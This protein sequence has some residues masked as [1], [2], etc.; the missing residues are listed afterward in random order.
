MTDAVA[1]LRFERDYYA[2]LGV[3]RDATS[4][5]IRSHFLSLSREFHPDRQS[6][7]HDNA[8]LVA[9]ANAQYAVLDRAYKVLLDPVKRRVYDIY[10]EK[11]SRR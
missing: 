8:A 6:R 4:D 9:A 11:V 3:P 2:L 10:G 7:R 5:D 1:S